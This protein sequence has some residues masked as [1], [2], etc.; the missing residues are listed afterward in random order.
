MLNILMACA[1]WLVIAAVRLVLI[2]LG[3]VTVPLAI[4]FLIFDCSS[5]Q[6]FTDYPKYG[7]WLWVSAPRWLWIWGNDRDGYL[8]DRRGWWADQCNGDHLGFFSMFKWAAIRNP[9]NNMRFVPFI[10]CDLAQCKV[11][12]LAGQHYVRDKIGHHGWQFVKAD[13]P[14]FNYFGFYLVTRPLFGS[15][16]LVIRL[17]HKIEPRHNDTDWSLEPQKAWK[18]VTFRVAFKDLA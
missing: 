17:G 5:R 15:R 9:V 6:R 2:L 16:G 8:G 14:V 1:M 7:Y 18:G 13:G 4:W 11:A 3:L 10:G 12:L